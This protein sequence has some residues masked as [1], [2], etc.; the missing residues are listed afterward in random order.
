MDKSK[1]LAEL[2]SS[3]TIGAVLGLI[4]YFIVET[5]GLPKLGRF[6]LGLPEMILLGAVLGVVFYLFGRMTQ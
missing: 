2:F 1:S 3:V 4:F 5:V 6:E